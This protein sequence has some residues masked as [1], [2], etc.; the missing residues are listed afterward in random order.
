MDM[1]TWTTL[2]A[3]HEF[4]QAPGLAG[5]AH[6]TTVDFGGAAARYVRLTI[7]SNWGTLPQFG[8]SE[9]RFYYV[10]V[11]AREPK[12]ATG[13]V[14]VNPN[15]V[16]LS[17]RSGRETASH[18]LYLSAD[19]QAVVDGTVPAVT[20]TQASYA[21]SSLV[22]GATYYWK[23]VE[24][25]EAASPSTWESNVWSFSTS[26]YI[27]IDD[28][29]RYS[30]ESPN[31]IF[32]AWVDG[33]GFSEDEFF[34][35][36]NPGNGTGAGVGHDI[37][38]SGG[39]NYGKTI[40]ETV[41]VHGGKQSMPLYYDNSSLA[42]SEAERT[43]KTAQDWTTNDANTLALYFRGS[44]AG[45]LELS[46]DHF[47]MNGVGTDIYGTADQGRFVYKQLTGDGTVV[48]RVDRL[49]NTNTNGWAKAGVMIRQSLDAG[50]TWAFA[51][52][53][54]ANGTHLQARLTAGAGATSDTV[55][56][57]PTTQTTA[58]IPL[59]VKLER[60][61]DQFTAS[62]AMGETPTT[63]IA[64]PWNPQTISMNAQVYI[65]L[66]VTSH[67]A[68][69]VTQA[70]FSNVTT[71]G[72]VTGQWQ[73]ASLGIDQPAGNM[74]DTL[75]LAVEDSSGHKATA[76][77]TDAYAVLAGV[78][79]QWSIPLSTLTSAGVKTNSIKKMVIGVG[80]KTKPASGATGLIYIDDIGFGRPPA[81]Q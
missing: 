8:L 20:P 73:S 52:A 45:W 14:G 48:A 68:G 78:W 12:P 37:W 71:T 21:P 41:I 16:V 76:I 58:Q 30:N 22:L 33:Y 36:G 50:S 46:S 35:T 67:A 69:V 1:S 40:A 79:T 11:F 2:D 62:Y 66:A 60:K 23:V 19:K 56:T 81:T 65:G 6:N 18:S 15:E 74:P 28:F 7:N 70:E 49:G 72:N 10:P 80:D 4:A 27:A 38:T 43:W 5:Y 9:V 32:Q 64:N 13:Q 61:G 31:R 57:L 29:E 51:L 53:S 25:N 75:Y 17:W 3:A 42:T 54:P 77:N 59:W 47:L 44:P 24:V 26:E 55:L 63:W 34:P 39:A